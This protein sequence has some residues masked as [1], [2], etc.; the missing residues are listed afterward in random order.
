MFHIHAIR[1]RRDA[2]FSQAD[3]I[4]IADLS[5]SNQSVAVIGNPWIPPGGFQ[6]LRKSSLLH[7]EYLLLEYSNNLAVI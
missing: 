4:H 3:V 5:G 6:F 1:A 2:S 7:G